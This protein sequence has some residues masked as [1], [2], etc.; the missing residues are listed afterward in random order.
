[1]AAIS[2]VQVHEFL[3]LLTEL[4]LIPL[5]PAKINNNKALRHL[6]NL[7]SLK[8]SIALL[9]KQTIRSMV[10]VFAKQGRFTYHLSRSRQAGGHIAT[11][12][13]HFLTVT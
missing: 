4:L 6:S 7:N 9:L 10:K 8:W 13:Y 3:L 2:F 12:A 1:M 11:L 5:D